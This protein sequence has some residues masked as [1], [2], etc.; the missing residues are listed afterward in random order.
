MES[1][2]GLASRSSFDEDAHEKPILSHTDSMMSSVSQPRRLLPKQPTPPPVPPVTVNESYIHEEDTQNLHLIGRPSE[3]DVNEILSL[4]KVKTSMLALGACERVKK[5]AK[6]HPVDV[7]RSPI[8]KE[9]LTILKDGPATPLA[10][11]AIS[12]L[13]ALALVPEGRKHIVLLGGALPIVKFLSRCDLNHS[14]TSKALQ[15]L[16]NLAADASNRRLLREANAV[17]VG[18]LEM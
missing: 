4:L 12:A 16:M 13:V 14:N 1:P 18:A 9:L 15:L 7:I 5:L 6:A 17:E 3:G 11:G 2:D 8:L 10:G